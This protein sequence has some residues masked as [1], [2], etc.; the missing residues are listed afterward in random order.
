MSA[1]SSLIW[2]WR[3]P[4][5]RGAAGRCIGRTDLPIDPRRAKGLARRIQATA[6]R[7][8]LPRVVYT[9]PLARCA[10][11]GRWLKRWGWRHVIDEAL[12]EIDFG[13]WDGLPW[14]GIARDEID[15]WCSDFTYW[16]PGGGE[17]L[18]R[19]LHRANGWAAATT[20]GPHLVVV[21]HAGWMA[22]RRWSADFGDAAPLPHTWPEPPTFEALWKLPAADE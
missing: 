22:A 10:S 18:A 3:H 12:L 21:A 2:A 15:N 9:S 8:G 19:L 14:D 13:R 20:A 5:P 4:Q 1:A 17:S 11:V 7:H 16:Q 6:R